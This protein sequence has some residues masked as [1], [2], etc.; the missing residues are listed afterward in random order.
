MNGDKGT[1]LGSFESA[2]VFLEKAA[3]GIVAIVLMMMMVLL[4]ADAIGRY[5]FLQPVVGAMEITEMYLLGA[6]AFLPL[7]TLQRENGHV[8]LSTF[9]A[10]LP[11]KTRRLAQIVNTGLALAVFGVIA[12]QMGRVALE[13]FS[14]GRETAGLVS[15]PIWCGWALACMGTSIFC[16]QLALGLW[17]SIIRQDNEC[18]K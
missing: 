9:Q 10:L 7:A 5:L 15:L 4:T 13:N 2:I 8:S 12:F 11:E 1:E 18:K 6:V 3:T 17:Q 16:L 14:A